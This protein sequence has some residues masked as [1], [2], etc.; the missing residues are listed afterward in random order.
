MST[1]NG[2]VGSH[3]EVRLFEGTAELDRGSHEVL[4]ALN[5][6]TRSGERRQNSE[7]PAEGEAEGE[8]VR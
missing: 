6:Q 3:S 8:E 1:C 7:Q 4:K 5:R 2:N